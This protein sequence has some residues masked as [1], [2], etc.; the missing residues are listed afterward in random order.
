[1]KK[2]FF[3]GIFTGYILITFL[4]T[5]LILLTSF[6]V[7]K[8]F[9]IDSLKE[10][11]FNLAETLKVS[12]KPFYKNKDFSGMDYLAKR[13]GAKIQTRIT[14][15]TPDGK[16]LAD[17][18]KNPELME[19]HR[20][21]DEIIKAL[22]GK[23]GSSLRFS[24]TVKE[25]MLYVAVPIIENNKI[26]GVLRV[27][28][29]LKKI[30]SLLD[31]IK[32]RIIGIALIILIICFVASLIISRGFSK[33]VE[34][35]ISASNRLSEGDFDARVIIKSNNELS[36]LS[37]NFNIMAEQVKKLFT[38]LDT[39]K[40]ELDAIISSLREGLLVID[41]NDKIVLFNKSLEK[42][43]A[44]QITKGRNYW[45][46]VRNPLFKE[47]VDNVRAGKENYSCEI[48]IRN[49][50][51][52]IS[53][54]PVALVK[55]I[56]LLF[57]DISEIKNLEQ[58]KKDFVTNVSHELRTPLTAIKGF[59]ETLEEDIQGEAKEYID[60][61]L[62]HTDRLI[63]IVNDLLVLGELENRNGELAYETIRIDAVINKVLKLFEDK[64][65]SKGLELETVFPEKIPVI[66]G[67]TF[68]IEQMLINLV[69]NA[70]KYTEKGRITITT[71]FSGK[72]LLIK[73]ED[74]GIGIPEN[75][76]SRIFERF[77]VCDKSRSRKLGGTGLGLSI[78]KH[79]TLLHNGSLDVKS[80]PGQG[81]VFTISLPAEDTG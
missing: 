35:L 16:V 10:N 43:F 55:N 20:T 13:M 54:S 19:N 81:T 50:N 28:L 40:R 60:I 75:D 1:M 12:V 3:S 74:T 76:I 21:R 65:R 38:E 69:D 9:Y 53:A 66:N 25:E 24:N 63:N 4:L 61:I 42:I 45:E 26:E 41:K 59:A 48:E 52:F 37:N 57:Y 23:M 68:K 5:L 71:E 79:I 77:Y 2:S 51:F 44:V 33:P 70:L 46:I 17:S 39:K 31:T 15:I 73:I 58:I 47:I 8:S 49:K 72:K 62:N 7:I 18:E 30:N 29:Y 64:A 80:T 78:V 27:S 6:S 56:A 36:T 32:A 22:E 34:E 14:V 11:L 67:D